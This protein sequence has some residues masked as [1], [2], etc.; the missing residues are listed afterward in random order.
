VKIHGKSV[1]GFSLAA[2]NLNDEDSLHLQSAGI[3]G[4]RAMGCGIFN[5]VMNSRQLEER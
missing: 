5:P 4:R 2:H 3:G 1:I